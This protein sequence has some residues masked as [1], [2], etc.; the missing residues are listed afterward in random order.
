MLMQVTQSIKNCSLKR[1]TSSSWVAADQG[2]SKYKLAHL[3]M[4]PCDDGK[5]HYYIFSFH[6]HWRIRFIACHQ[7][8]LLHFRW[9]FCCYLL[10]V[11][12]HCLIFLYLFT[13]PKNSVYTLFTMRK[14]NLSIL[15]YN[16]ILLNSELIF[17]ALRNHIYCTQNQYLL[18]S[19]LICIAFR[20]DIDCTAII[21]FML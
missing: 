9:V 5:W 21:T 13:I 14:K 6:F 3:W 4:L 11:F 20:N 2:F 10:V 17:I 8:N 18:K 16:A 7:W 15:V 12:G 1:S 19:K